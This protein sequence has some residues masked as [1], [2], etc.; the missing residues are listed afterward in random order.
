MQLIIK[1]FLADIGL[2][3]K[4]FFLLGLVIQLRSVFSRF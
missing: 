3:G 4:V 2:E 1:G